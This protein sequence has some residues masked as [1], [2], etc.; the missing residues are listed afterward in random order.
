MKIPEIWY[1]VCWV[2]GFLSLD[3]LVEESFEVVY[4]KN[5]KKEE[6]QHLICEDLIRMHPNKTIDLKELRAD[7]YRHFNSSS[8]YAYQRQLKPSSFEKLLLNQTMFGNYLILNGAVCF[9]AN[10]K[11]EIEYINVILY[12]TNYFTVK[13]DTFDF[14]QMTH[15]ID[16]IDQL[17]VLE[18]AHPYSD[19]D[20]RNSRF[21]CLNDCF[22]RRFRL[23]RYLYD[24]NE[25]G[26]IYLNQPMNR[27]IEENE[28]VC[29]N[30]CKRD[31][32][33]I[34]QLVPVGANQCKEAKIFEAQPK[35]SEFDYWLQFIGLVCSFAGLSIH[36]LT[37]VAIEFIASKVR[38]RKVRIGLFYLKWVILFLCL[39]SFCYLVTLTILEHKAE[40]SDPKEKEKTKIIVQ[41]KILRVAICVV[42][43]W[44]VRH[45][46]EDKT[47]SEIEKATDRAL[48]RTLEG[49]NVN[50]GKKSYET[51]YQIQPKVLFFRKSRCFYLTIH[52]NYQMIPSEPRL[53]FKFDSNTNYP[54]VYLLSENENLNGKSLEYSGYYVFRKRI[55][56]R[57]KSGGKCVDYEEK[58]AGN[59]TERWNCVKRCIQRNYIER[60]NRTTFGTNDF[61][62]VIDRDWFSST[63]WN[64]SH[65][66]KIEKENVSNAY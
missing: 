21:F 4:E 41:P 62:P 7:L 58:Y 35:L 40:W 2:F 22:K 32:C 30:K 46:Y 3:T 61:H 23:A 44:Y 6:V 19:C 14:V 50:Y 18:Q 17:V 15:V 66:I 24:G 54:R 11:K 37:S 51:S 42:I 43:D 49:I 52:P 56:R 13:R 12:T 8:N 38:K 9:L 57:L 36:E 26:L 53:I 59:C 20:K 25:T 10:D 55:G 31:N 27:S 16:Q 28:K 47:M 1:F 60:F 65:P 5:N 45:R 29:F 63:E 64:T 48:V 39:A 33:K 34:N